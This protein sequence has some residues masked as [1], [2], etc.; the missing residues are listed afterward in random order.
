VEGGIVD[1]LSAARHQ[2]VTA[3]DGR[4]RQENFDSYRFSRMLEA[5]PARRCSLRRQ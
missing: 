3:T 2:R 1:A 5:P 4:V